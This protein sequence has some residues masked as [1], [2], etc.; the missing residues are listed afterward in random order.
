[1]NSDNC[2]NCGGSGYVARP[3]ELNGKSDGVAFIRMKCP[4]CAGSGKKR[5]IPPTTVGW[6][7]SLRCLRKRSRP[8]CPLRL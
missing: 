3:V 5:P 4:I 6:P 1:V 2:P 7:H 8:D